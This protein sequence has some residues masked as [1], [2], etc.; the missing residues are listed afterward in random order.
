MSYINDFPLSRLHIQEDFGFHNK[1]V[2]LVSATLTNEIIQNIVKAY[3]DSVTNLDAALLQEKTNSW[4]EKV[5]AADRKVDNLYIGLSYYL[6][7]MERHPDTSLA[8]HGKKAY[9]IIKKY[10]SI[11]KLNYT[12]EYGTLLNTMQDFNA[13]SEDT[14]TALQLSPWLEALTLAMAQFDVVRSSQAY[15]GSQYK[16]GYSKQMR[17]EADAA[18]RKLVDTVNALSAALGTDEFEHF[19]S[20]LNYYIADEVTKLKQRDTINAKKK[21]EEKDEEEKQ[22]DTSTE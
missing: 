13:L 10:G 18:Y 5:E 11:T 12:E 8:E 22:E 7:G 2:A 3:R 1:V 16:A 4:T 20:Q 21:E 17:Q 6:R 15:E 14:L 19:I 9:A